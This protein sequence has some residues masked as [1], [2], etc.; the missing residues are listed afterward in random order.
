MSLMV[1]NKSLAIRTD[2]AFLMRFLN[3]TQ[4]AGKI[5]TTT[6][7]NEKRSKSY[8]VRESVGTCGKLTMYKLHYSSR[9]L[10]K[11]EMNVEWLSCRQ[12]S[13]KEENKLGFHDG[14]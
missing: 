1:P 2:K 10:R 9:S 6:R 4:K 13:W 5:T 11:E 12:R 7:E 8:V 14:G 3:Y